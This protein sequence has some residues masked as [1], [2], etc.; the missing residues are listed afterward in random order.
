MKI[1]IDARCLMQKNYSGVSWYAFNL[2]SALFEIDRRNDYVLFYNNSKPI[3]MPKFNL[4]NVK[5]AEFNHSNKLLN[6]SLNFF[7]RPKIDQMI[8]GVDL[9]LIPNINFMALSDNCRKVV[10]VHDLSFL[11]YPQFFTTKSRIWHKILMSK[12]LLQ[13]AD[14]II[15][16]SSSTKRDLI[17]LLGINENKIKVIYEG[18]DEKFMLVKNFDELERVK[19][20]YKLPAKFILYLGTLEPRKNIESIISAYN[21]LATDCQ[22]VIGGGDG[23]KSHKIKRLAGLNP[24][25]KLIGYV[26]EEDK[27]GLYTLADLFVY[28]SYYEGFGLPPIEAMACGTPVIVGANS[29]Q[30]EVVG[31]AGLLVDPYN[32]NEIAEAMKII[33][34]DA[35]I[36][37]GLIANGFEN[38]KRFKWN[39]T[40]QE[41]LKIF[42]ELRGV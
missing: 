34:K 22:L 18:V 27:R 25:V 8:G 41:T 4:A 37:T 26:K 23:W 10:T 3:G 28:P 21:Q 42:E 17:D 7:N 9:M 24:K 39:E 36:R 30:V 40:A 19:K 33:L 15:A 6:L 31:S 1:G 13:N 35:K 32:V 20:R 38:V 2:L 16:V 12:K 5:Y 11:R 14:A 29:S